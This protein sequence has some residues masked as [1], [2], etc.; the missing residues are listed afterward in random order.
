[1]YYSKDKPDYQ[2]LTGLHIKI[3]V[4]CLL[5]KRQQQSQIIVKHI[6]CFP[7]KV[8]R[9][10]PFREK[11]SLF[12]NLEISLSVPIGTLTRI[13]VE[14]I[15]RRK[16]AKHRGENKLSTFFF[17]YT[18]ALCTLEED[19]VKGRG[20]FPSRWGLPRAPLGKRSLHL[21]ILHI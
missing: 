14:R 4:F 16:M 20:I 9:K 8:L 7:L 2:P 13:S 21:Y 5:F 17:S 15:R 12:L 11:K 3:I 19:V 10:I 18:F 1:M 6:C